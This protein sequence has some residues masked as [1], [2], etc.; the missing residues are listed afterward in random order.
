MIL[1]TTLS[2]SPRT[3]APA[4]SRRA[5]VRLAPPAAFALL[6][7]LALAIPAPTF[8]AVDPAEAPQKSLAE[9]RAAAQSG[10]AQALLD[11]ADELAYGEDVTDESRAESATW[12]RRAAEKGDSDGQ[13]QL[14][15]M[16]WNGEGVEENQ[17]E[18]VRWFRRAAE[19]GKATSQYW[20]ATAYEF[21]DGGLEADPVEAVKWYR[22]AAEQGHASSQAN[23]GELYVEGKGV[24]KDDATGLSWLK[25]AVDQDNPSGQH[26]LAKLYAEGRGVPKDEAEA[27]RLF[28]LAA[29]NDFSV[30]IIALGQ[31]YEEGRGVKRNPICA[32]FWYLVAA[33]GGYAEGE[34]KGEALAAKLSEVDRTEGERMLRATELIDG[35]IFHPVCPG[36]R[37]SVKLD[38]A[39]LGEFLRSMEKVTG[40]KLVFDE[41]IASMTFSLQAKDV[42]WETA[43]TRALEGKGLDWTREGDEIRVTPKAQKP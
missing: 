15:L 40:L 6:A 36:E 5:K 42:P 18:A 11:L 19:Q 4:P 34:E 29:N 37:M 30:S 20:L 12:Y 1:Q 22:K 3:S 33:D 35:E 10:E 8:G 13:H 9:L 14:A 28:E 27:A 39:A 25:K 38:N 23:L 32:Y 7:S 16:F 26:A 41:K 21:G 17:V 31:A 2:G 43:L 24:P